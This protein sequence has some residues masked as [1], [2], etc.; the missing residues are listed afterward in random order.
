MEKINYSISSLKTKREKLSFAK[1]RFLLVLITS[2]LLFT[3]NMM[4]QDFD[5]S[6]AKGEV[7]AQGHNETLIEGD[8]FKVKS[9]RIEKIPLPKS[10]ESVLEDKKQKTTKA[11]AIRL[12]I[13]GEFPSKPCVV[14]INGVGHLIWE[15]DEN[16]LHLL[17]YGK[18]FE[19]GSE[20]LISRNDINKK[21]MLPEPLRVP[22]E[23]Q[24]P[25]RGKE[26]L[27]QNI[28]LS[29]IGCDGAILATEKDCVQITIYKDPLREFGQSPNHSRYLQI[30]SEE[31]AT[32]IISVK[33]FERLK[34]GEWVI[35][36]TAK[37]ELGGTMVGILDK[38]SLGKR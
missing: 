23:L 20:I 16:E 14:W 15:G 34:D 28:G 13:T 21:V 36:K 8:G 29:Y 25:A 9:Y 10:A 37:G 22:S 12:V 7:I 1:L 27:R 3:V 26:E 30:G 19:E 11:V 38:S 33:E 32:S 35:V 2:L 24:R 18:L 5:L 6:R 4:A 31:F 17:F